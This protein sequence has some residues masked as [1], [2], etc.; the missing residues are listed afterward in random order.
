[1]QVS[2]ISPNTLLVVLIVAAAA[3]TLSTIAGRTGFV[4]PVVVLELI[5][6]VLIG[7]YV[8]ALPVGPGVA[9]FKS[10]GLALLFFFAGYEIDLRRIA[11]RP[12]ELGLAGWMV[13]LAIAYPAVTILHVAGMDLAILYGGSAIATTAMGTLIPTLSDTGELHTRFGTFLLAAGATGE[14]G[15]ILLLTLV[16]ST[17]SSLHNAL[18]LVAFLTVSALVAVF[19]VRS[20]GRTVP[21][22]IRTLNA[23]SQLAVR[24]VLVL[25][26]GL[27]LLAYRLG[28]DLLIGGFAA[29]LITGEVLRGQPMS[30]FD[31]KLVGIAY[32]VFVPF[33]FVASGIALDISAFS[34]VS[35]LLRTGMFAVLMLV[36]RG[37]PALLLYRRDL[38][39][40]DRRALALLSATQLPMVLAI[41]TLATADGH[42]SASIAADL[43]GAAVLTTLLFPM[44][45][46]RLRRDRDAAAALADLGEPLTAEAQAELLAE[47]PPL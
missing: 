1:M 15:P 6:G 21:V 14:F 19:A 42:M 23:S 25:V 9:L 44:I 7:P 46:L 38:D 2:T 43:V 17:Q 10:L 45:G 31:S 40:R 18:I 29:G 37:V 36:V 24:W 20:S 26:F 47:R 5:G 27:A 22:L 34:T 13:S 39:G 11:G 3:A 30:D 28:L 4:A 32:G 41:T 16:L 33:F 8:L 12:L 35:G